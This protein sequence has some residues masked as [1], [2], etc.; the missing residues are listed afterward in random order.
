M[1]VDAERARQVQ[2]FIDANPDKASLIEIINE[3]LGANVQQRM[4]LYNNIGGNWPMS[5]LKTRQRG[6]RSTPRSST[7][8]PLICARIFPKR[9]STNSIRR[10]M[11]RVLRLTAA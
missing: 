8:S 6:A 4:L 3:P 5:S 1:R 2:A 11:I 10:R 9:Y 7:S